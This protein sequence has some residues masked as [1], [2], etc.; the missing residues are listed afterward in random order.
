MGKK[1]LVTGAGGFIGTALGS[2]LAQKRES[3]VLGIG[4]RSKAPSGDLQYH[5][6][7]LSH[8]KQIAKFL[9]QQKPDFIFHL[10]GGRAG[11]ASEL[12]NDNVT[13]TINL[14]E[15][16]RL[17]KNYHP[18]V[19]VT[20]SA[21]EC[22]DV[23]GARRPILENAPSHPAGLYGWIKL[24]QTQAALYYASLGEDII[25]AR[26]FNISGPGIRP[27]MAAGRF[28]NELVRLEKSTSKVL[29][30][31]NL[32]G[33]RDFLDIR[34]ICAALI[35]LS[36]KGK[37]GEMYNVCS[38]QGIMMREFLK[39]MIKASKAKGIKVNE[40]KKSKPGVLYAVGSNV[41]LK[42]ITGWK[43]QY[44]LLQSIRDTISFYRQQP[45]N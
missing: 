35:A 39:V 21:A 9:S 1:I 4:R 36:V 40:D 45:V 33:V 28:A 29:N 25:I 5:Q 17:I 20:G 2:C 44:S 31:L 16:I 38:K 27:D 30:V 11:E 32:G 14:F 6:I 13:T 3:T 43:A 22:G 8:K 18:R 34:D 23:P 41:K 24:L 7:D 12:F 37:K 15:S 10:A 19:I 26:L 42:K